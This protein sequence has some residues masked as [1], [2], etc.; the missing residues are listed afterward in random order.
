MQ[1]G[2]VAA[3]FKIACINVVGA[4]DCTV[5]DLTINPRVSALRWPRF[6]INIRPPWEWHQRSL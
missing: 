2:L 3:E 6:C 1:L 5:N 4:G